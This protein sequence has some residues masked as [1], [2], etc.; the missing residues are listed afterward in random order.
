MNNVYWQPT[1]TK[2]ILGLKQSTPTCMVSGETGRYPLSISIK[3][4]MISYW[5]KLL[6]QK[7]SKLSNIMYKVI[8]QYNSHGVYTSPWLSEIKNILDNTGHSFIWLSQILPENFSIVH[9]VKNSLQDQYVQEWNTIINNSLNVCYTELLNGILYLKTISP[10]CHHIIENFCVNLELLTINC[11]LKLDGIV[12]AQDLPEIV[13][14]VTWRNWVMNFIFSYNVQP[15]LISEKR[16]YL[17]IAK[18]DLTF[19]NL[20]VLCPINI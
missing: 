2:Y 5:S 17:Y 1:R 9:A 4:G 10:H 8:H 7:E 12:V 15:Y 11:Q 14:N 18:I 20:K 13:I 3:C 19:K 6:C 16:T